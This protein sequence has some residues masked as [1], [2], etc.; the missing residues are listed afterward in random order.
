MC[1]FFITLGKQGEGIIF[2][3]IVINAHHADST[4]IP[5]QILQYLSLTSTM[6]IGRTAYALAA[7]VAPVLP[8]GLLWRGTSHEL[9]PHS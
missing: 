5:A 4:E 9:L 1:W 6:V 7:A 8:T 3:H 2:S